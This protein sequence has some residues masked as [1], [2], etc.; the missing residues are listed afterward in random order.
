MLTISKRYPAWD[1]TSKVLAVAKNMMGF[2][3]DTAPHQAFPWT[4]QNIMPAGGAADAIPA[5][6]LFSSARL[7]K[8][9]L[10][11]PILLTVVFEDGIYVVSDAVSD[12]YG[13]GSDLDEA[14]AEYSEML[15]EFY[16]ELLDSEDVLAPHLRAQL[17]HLRVI[18]RQE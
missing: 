5:Q 17:S 16:E 13:A 11:Q 7:G 12:Q 14:V 2:G 4:F 18:L 1:A 6:Y 15:I 3:Q 9:I 8:Y 10:T